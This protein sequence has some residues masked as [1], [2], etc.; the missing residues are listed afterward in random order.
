[1]SQAQARLQ[2]QAILLDIVEEG[3]Q[4]AAIVAK[5]GIPIL[6][7]W[8]IPANEDLFAA[9]AAAMFGAADACAME[10]GKTAPT[11]ISVKGEGH[12]FSVFGMDDQHL[13]VVLGPAT[14]E[15]VSHARDALSDA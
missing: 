11:S 6:Q 14:D 13:L 7:E 4:A 15:Q 5:D 8:N 2:C 12:E 10:S 1:M 9:M 3:A